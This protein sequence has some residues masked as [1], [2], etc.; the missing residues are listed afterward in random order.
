MGWTT[1]Y[2]TGK[3]DFREEIREKLDDS[4]LDV[5]PG[6]TGTFSLADETHDLFWVDEDIK[7]RAFKEAIGSKLIWKYRLKFYPN[8]EAFTAAQDNRSTTGLSAEEMHLMEEMKA[9]VR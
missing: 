5:M 1:L 9:A 2:I 3:G 4:N 6:Y 7:L 8:L